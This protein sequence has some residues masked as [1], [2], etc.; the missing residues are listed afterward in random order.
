MELQEL[1]GPAGEV[2]SGVGFQILVTVVLWTIG[3][4]VILMA[5]RIAAGHSR[6]ALGVARG[7]SLVLSAALFLGIVFFVGP[8]IATFGALVLAIAL[9]SAWRGPAVGAR[10][11]ARR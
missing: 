11:A 5:T 7:A 4:G 9:E 10:K 3:R 8:A 2:A 1:L 6:N